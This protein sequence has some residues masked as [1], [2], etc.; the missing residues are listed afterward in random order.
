MKLTSLIRAEKKKKK[1]SSKQCVVIAGM[2][3][4]YIYELNILI[5]I[6]SRSKE[7]VNNNVSSFFKNR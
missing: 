2:H 5:Y 1:Q 4:M 7:N 3:K 6:Y